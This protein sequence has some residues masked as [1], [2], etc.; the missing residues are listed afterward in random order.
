MKQRFEALI[1]AKGPRGAWAFLPIP[2][3]VPRVFGTKGRV[4]VSGTLNGFAFRSSLMPEGDGTH[5]MMV[6]KE[7]QAGAKAGP[8]DRVKVVM[9]EDVAERTVEIP[10]G[11]AAAL[12]AN[13]K[14]AA[15]FEALSYSRKKEYTDWISGAKRVETRARLREAAP[16][17]L[18]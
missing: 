6:S 15:G 8:G 17:V 9:E 18:G 13:G 4:A 11:L 2:F 12:K 5:A 10:E 14:A 3:E 16:G 1:V 7:L